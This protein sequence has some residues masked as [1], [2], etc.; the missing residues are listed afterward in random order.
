M[1]SSCWRDIYELFATGD[2]NWADPLYGNHISI[3]ISAGVGGD[4]G[5]Y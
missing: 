4:S 3:A 1:Q 2:Y 5:G